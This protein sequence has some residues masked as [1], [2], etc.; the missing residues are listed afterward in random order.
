MEPDEVIRPRKGVMSTSWRKTGAGYLLCLLV[1]SC[2]TQPRLFVQ[3]DIRIVLPARQ[4]TDEQGHTP[5]KIWNDGGTTQIS[6]VDAEAHKFDVYF[7][8]RLRGTS[9]N[10]VRGPGTIY[11]NGYPG[12]S[13]SVLVIDQERFKKT[14]LKDIQLPSATN[15]A[16]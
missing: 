8:H 13:N 14:V 7:D 3:G 2:V 10:F 6:V 9:S 16:R 1:G 12:T 4:E 11:L 5:F 15:I